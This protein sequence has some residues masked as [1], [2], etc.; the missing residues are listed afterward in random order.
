MASNYTAAELA[1]F[2]Q[3]KNRIKDGYFRKVH[4]AH[5]EVWAPGE[6]KT[7][8]RVLAE[9][10]RD[11]SWLKINPG[12][13]HEGTPAKN[14]YRLCIL[15]EGQDEFDITLDYVKGVKELLDVD[16]MPQLTRVDPKTGEPMKRVYIDPRSTG[17]MGKSD[18]QRQLDDRVRSEVTKAMVS[19][20]AEKIAEVVAQMPQEEFEQVVAELPADSSQASQ[21]GTGRRVARA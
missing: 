19:D 3:I 18:A 11:R 5:E 16:N 6:T 15:G 7:M 9:W 2:V 8:L 21:I 13:V 12:D 10:F 17:A 20:G 14:E 4:N 1:D